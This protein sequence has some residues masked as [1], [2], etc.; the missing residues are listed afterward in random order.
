M[1]NVTQDLDARLAQLSDTLAATEAEVDALSLPAATGDADAVE[2]LARATAT[3]SQLTADRE[4]LDRAR[5]ASAKQADA[6]S[7]KRAEAKRQAA[8][9]RATGHAER[10]F[11]MA[12]RIDAI[13]L[14]YRGIVA[15][16][17]NVEHDLW[18]ALREAD[19]VVSDSVVGRRNLVTHA[20][21]A[22]R[23]ATAPLGMRTR[24]CASVAGV[25][26]SFLLG[27]CDI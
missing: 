6:A 18:H 10:I 24:P 8:K 27:D 26:W 22:V 3:I 4:I 1:N 14:E 25:T 7:A 17:S 11:R 2:K 19:C 9:E 23:S 20:V 5:A 13:A 16:M 15:E 21:S 12:E